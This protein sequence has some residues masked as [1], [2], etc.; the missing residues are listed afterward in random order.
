[1]TIKDIL[2]DKTVKQLEKIIQP[3][4][5]GV[6]NISTKK[7]L[8]QPSFSVKIILCGLLELDYINLLD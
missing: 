8:L 1:M 3:H 7:W 5:L 4:Y 2:N 6:D